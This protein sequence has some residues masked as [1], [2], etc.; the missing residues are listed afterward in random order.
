MN[1]I[2]AHGRQRNAYIRKF[3]LLAAAAQDKSP[4]E[5]WTHNFYR[6]PARFSTRFARAA[7]ELFS[8]PGDLILDPYMG[9]GTAIVEALAAARCAV[10]N[11]LNSLAAF[12]ARVKITPLKSGDVDAIL[13]W[14]EMDVPQLGYCQ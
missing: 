6:Y 12:V 8:E 9:G 7:I 14:V 1:M 11:D 2:A 3:T 13:D 5:G 10:G 4:V